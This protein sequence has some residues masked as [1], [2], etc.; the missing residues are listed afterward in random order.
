[1]FRRVLFRSRSLDIATVAAE[2]LA[3]E[4]ELELRIVR[5]GVVVEGNHG[6]GLDPQTGSRRTIVI[7][8]R[9]LDR[10]CLARPDRL[11]G[12]GQLDLELRRD[13]ILD[14]E[15]CL[16]DRRRLRVEPQ[17]DWPRG[18]GRD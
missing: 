1:E 14:L 11:L 8:R 18:G 2:L 13:E 5:E 9:H 4:S 12:G 16:A 7:A 10:E 15:L 6:L 3:D 17:R